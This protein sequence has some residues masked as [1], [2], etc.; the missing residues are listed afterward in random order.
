LPGTCT[1]LTVNDTRENFANLKKEAMEIV[2]KA[3]AN[4]GVKRI[5]RIKQGSENVNYDKDTEKVVVFNSLD[6]NR[7]YG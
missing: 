5:E 2:E 7:V 3:V 4:M 1:Y 6:T